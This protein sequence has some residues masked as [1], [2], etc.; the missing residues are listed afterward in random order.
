MTKFCLCC[1]LLALNIVESGKHP[2]EKEV[3]ASLDFSQ[4][5]AA[6]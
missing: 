1:V 3:E 4:M 5:M 2:P 6:F